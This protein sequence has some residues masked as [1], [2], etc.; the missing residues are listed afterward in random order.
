MQLKKVVFKKCK[1]TNTELLTFSREFSIRKWFLKEIPI[2]KG[3]KLTYV[4]KNVFLF[5]GPEQP[6]IYDSVKGENDTN[7]RPS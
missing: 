5:L 1:N 3:L 2:Q 4:Q 6:P 7:Q